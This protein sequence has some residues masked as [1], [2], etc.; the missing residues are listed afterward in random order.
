MR[1]EAPLKNPPVMERISVRYQDLDPYGHVNNAVHL[2]FFKVARIAYLKT[3]AEIRGLGPLV[4]GDIPG[5]RYVIAEA[6][7]RYKA[8]IYFDD[9]L[10]CTANVRTVGNRSFTIDHELRAGES[11]ERGRLVAEGSSAQVFFDPET[12][13]VQL[14]PIGS[15]PPSPN[16]KA[17][18]RSPLFRRVAELGAGMLR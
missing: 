5:V 4:A 2:E 13:E 18:P 16:S 10:Y 15:S 8:P 1:E 14:G 11:F 7:V 17:A 9:A 12:E 6:T 3:L